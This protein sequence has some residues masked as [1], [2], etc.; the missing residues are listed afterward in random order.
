MHW[1]DNW[2]WRVL[3]WRAWSSKIIILLS[4]PACL[5]AFIRNSFHASWVRATDPNIWPLIVFKLHCFYHSFLPTKW[6][7]VPLAVRTC[8]QISDFG[9]S[10]KLA[11][12]TEYY[13]T[14]GGMVPVKW[15]APEVCVQLQYVLTAFA[16]YLYL[17]VCS[18]AYVCPY[19]HM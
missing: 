4:T 16:T 3:C 12:E 7:C 1:S 6:L 10:K 13:V 8:F 5:I 2:K 11:D 14:S 17:Y 18:S 19:E 15:T 9:L